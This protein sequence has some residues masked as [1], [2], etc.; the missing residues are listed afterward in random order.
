VHVCL[1]PANHDRD[2]EVDRLLALGATM[3]ADRRR[4]DGAG[5]A[6][7]QDPAGNEF[8]ITRSSSERHA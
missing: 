7:L 4:P 1:Q 3:L 5:W 2:T 6:V 8:C